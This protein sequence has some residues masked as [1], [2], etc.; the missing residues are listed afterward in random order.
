MHGLA[1]LPFVNSSSFAGAPAASAGR[2]VAGW[3]SNSPEHLHLF[4]AVY[5]RCLIKVSGNAMNCRQDQQHYKGKAGP[6][7][8]YDDCRNCPPT[9][10]EKRGY[11]AIKQVKKRIYRA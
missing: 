9:G 10:G 5:H 8:S 7:V 4:G 3:Q 6:D 2:R 1:L 11:R